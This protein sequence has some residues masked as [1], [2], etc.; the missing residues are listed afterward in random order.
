MKPRE[1]EKPKVNLMEAAAS[2]HAPLDHPPPTPHH[3]PISL[4]LTFPGDR[5]GIPG[6]QVTAPS[7][8]VSNGRMGD[9]RGYQ[10]QHHCTASPPRS[11]QVWDSPDHCGY[12]SSKT[13]GCRVSLRIAALQL[14]DKWAKLK[15][16]T[17]VTFAC[18]TTG[19]TQ[20]LTQ[21]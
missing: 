3:W 9:T 1:L 11:F 14:T 4:L 8:R 12:F 5:S 6:L 17:G 10:K 18:Q 21:N 15:A 16:D 19:S 7:P 2:G 13:T 20:T